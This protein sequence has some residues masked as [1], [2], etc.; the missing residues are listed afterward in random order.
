MWNTLLWFIYFDF[1]SFIFSYAC[2]KTVTL[3]W[4]FVIPIINSGCIDW[5]VKFLSHI[6]TA[7]HKKIF[8]FFSLFVYFA[9][10]ITI[11]IQIMITQIWILL[12]I[13]YLISSPFVFLNVLQ[14]LR[15]KFEN[16]VRYLLFK[17]FFSS[18][19]VISYHTRVKCANSPAPVKWN[20]L[21]I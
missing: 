16:C 19:Y 2:K 17:F 7:I 14:I 10:V 11:F 15:L 18:N 13:N 8:F 6:L 1:F 12:R 20:Q 4:F 21:T 5:N 9:I 3:I